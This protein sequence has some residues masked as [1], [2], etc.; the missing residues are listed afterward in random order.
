MGGRSGAYADA[1]G[2]TALRWARCLRWTEGEVTYAELA[3]DFEL[4]VRRAPP[5][6]PEHLL[7]MAVLPL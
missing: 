6:R 1:Y 7:Q 4:T 3:L 5:A 2:P